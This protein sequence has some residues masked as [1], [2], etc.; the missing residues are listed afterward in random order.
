MATISATVKLKSRLNCWGTTPTSRASSVGAVLA[1]AACPSSSVS[2][3][4]GLHRPGE[5]AQQGGLARPVGTED[6]QERAARDLQVEGPEHRPAAQRDLEAADV[7][8][9]RA[10]ASAIASGPLPP[11]Q[12]VEE[13]G[14]AR[15]PP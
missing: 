13:E 7:V 12:Q 4:E 9:G 8:D 10:A 3:A 2:P 11:P 14:T 1:H 5:R 6:A 15:R